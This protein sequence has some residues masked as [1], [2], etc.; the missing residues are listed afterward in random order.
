MNSR[1]SGS[2]PTDPTLE[3]FLDTLWIEQG[4]SRNTLS[5]YRSDLELFAKRLGKPLAKAG[6]DDLQAYLGSR[7]RGSAA[8]PFSPRSQA[9]FLSAVRR[10]YRFLVRERIRHDDPTALIA[11]P[12]QGRPAG[13]AD[14]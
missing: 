12:R 2:R 5:A 8:T 6:P 4:L 11:G 7:H 9:R 10:Y 3:K 14:R 1:P 13:Y